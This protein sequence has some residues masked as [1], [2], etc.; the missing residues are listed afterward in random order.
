MVRVFKCE[1]IEGDHCGE[2]TVSVDAGSIEIRG[3]EAIEAAAWRKWRQRFGSSVGMASRGF[4]ILEEL[5]QYSDLGMSK[6]APCSY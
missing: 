2:V 3:S 4:T 5:E 6:T 1:I